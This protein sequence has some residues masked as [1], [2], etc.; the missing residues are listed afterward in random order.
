MNTLEIELLAADDREVVELER[1]VTAFVRRER[2]L[3]RYEDLE[4][5][6]GRPV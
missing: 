2:R 1:L 6:V 5:A 4:A 3:P